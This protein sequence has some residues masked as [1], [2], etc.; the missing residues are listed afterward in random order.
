MPFP[1]SLASRLCEPTIRTSSSSA[2]LGITVLS[3]WTGRVGLSRLRPLQSV[4]ATRTEHPC[5]LRHML[6]INSVACRWALRSLALCSSL[7]P[8]LLSVRERCRRMPSHCPAAAVQQ[9]QN[10]ANTGICQF[11]AVRVKLACGLAQGSQPL[12]WAMGQGT[13]GQGH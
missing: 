2:S 12:I 7:Q 6:V 10:T 13:Q 1:I 4:L 8:K 5:W 3:S 9:R 11:N